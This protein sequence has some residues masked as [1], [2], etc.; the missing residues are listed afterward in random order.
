[1]IKSQLTD[2][3]GNQILPMTHIN[4][5]ID[6]PNV[7]S[8]RVIDEDTFGDFGK[9]TREDLKKDL[10]I[11]LWK[12]YGKVSTGSFS[13]YDEATKTFSLNGITGI[14]WTTALYI[15]VLAD[16][17]RLTCPANF[18]DY[19]FDGVNI[20]GKI[21]TMMPFE[22]NNSGGSTGAF[23]LATYSSIQ[24]LNFANINSS[25]TTILGNKVRE[26]RHLALHKDQQ[27]A[28]VIECPEL[29]IFDTFGLDRNMSLYKCPKINYESFKTFVE[30]RST[31]FYIGQEVT[32]T[33]HPDVY[34]A[35]TGSAT[36]PFNEGTKEEWLALAELAISKNIIFVTL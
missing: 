5:V 7:V 8:E 19:H 6:A 32:V 24:V 23:Y 34:N 1:M 15:M 35:L 13:D 29:V 11:D 21:P 2:K 33:V 20:L 10:F 31:S 9:L 4:C 12:S 16:H 36:Y 25:K 14:D 17:C 30:R 18:I 22:Y 3:S 28:N 27:N 26:I